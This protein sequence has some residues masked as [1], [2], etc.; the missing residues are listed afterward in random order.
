[1]ILHG[2]WFYTYGLDWYLDRILVMVVASFV[3]VGSIIGFQRELWVKWKG[4][5]E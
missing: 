1:M 4:R 5:D 2:G 3:L